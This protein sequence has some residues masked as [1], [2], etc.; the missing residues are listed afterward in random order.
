MTT[1]TA[2]PFNSWDCFK[3]I[4]LV[5][6]FIDHVGAY[7]FVHE[8]WIRSIGR[9]SAPL[10]LFLAGYASS[11]RFSKKLL[12]LACVMEFSN[13]LAGHYDQSLNILFNIML[14][15]MV[16]RWME[17][18]G[19]VIERPFEWFIVLSI[20]AVFSSFFMQ[21][22][23]LGM[24]FAVCGYMKRYPERYSR[25]VLP[26]FLA[27]SLVVYAFNFL[28]FFDFGAFEFL[29]MLPFLALDYWLIMGM[30]LREMDTSKLPAWLLRLLTLTTRYSAEIYAY[31]LIA[32][33]WLT[34]Y[35][36]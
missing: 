33:S 6:M 11:Y 15:R 34:G 2:R 18:R 8:I 25:K 16:F 26:R 29:L 5:F 10:F 20:F 30:E 19:R 13:I 1:V 23:T 9:T 32:I 3:L 28:L 12:L 4:A 36:L 7:G 24:M 35:P 27:A 17:K 31:H 21:Y 14:C 22:G